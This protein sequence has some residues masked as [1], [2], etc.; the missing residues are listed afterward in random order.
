M[1]GPPSD[2][3]I[4]TRERTYFFSSRSQRTKITAMPLSPPDAGDLT[5]LVRGRGALVP[6]GRTG[7]CEEGR[8]Q[9]IGSGLVFKLRR[10]ARGDEAPV[11]DHG[12]AVGHAVGLVH[13]VRREKHGHA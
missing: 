11:V 10:R 9:R 13:I 1:S 7:E 5:H 8:F 3:T 2:A 4:W 12:D 6:D